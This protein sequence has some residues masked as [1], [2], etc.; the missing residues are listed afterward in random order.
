MITYLIVSP[1]I[2]FILFS[3]FPVKIDLQI[4]VSFDLF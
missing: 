1:A 4:L 3:F 2:N